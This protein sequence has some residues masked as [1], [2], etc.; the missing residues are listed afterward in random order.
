[1]NT[2]K[3][4]NSVVTV[5]VESDTVL[6]F[7]V[8][9]AGRLRF[10]TAKAHSALIQRAAMHGWKQRIADAAAMSRNPEN[11]QPASPED[12]MEAMAALIA[13]YESGSPEWSRR[14]SGGG[15]GVSPALVVEAV[16]RVKDVSVNEASAMIDRMAAADGTD[17]KA[18]IAK[19]RE[20]PTVAKT[21]LAIKAERLAAV[22]ADDSLLDGLK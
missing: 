21:M 18:A 11:G 19:L 17:R 3:R 12:K 6:V 4:S 2:T 20:A 7:D 22:P 14:G 1:M 16:A 9:G 15:S 10:D 8:L 13:H 5:T